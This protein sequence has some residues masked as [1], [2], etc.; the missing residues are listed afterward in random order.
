MS[1][2][3]AS[4]ATPRITKGLRKN[5]IQPMTKEAAKEIVLRSLLTL[6]AA[7]LGFVVSPFAREMWAY[8]ANSVLPRLSSEARL[9][10]L[11][12]LSTICLGLLVWIYSLTSKR[13]LLKNYQPRPGFPGVYLD[14]KN[15]E[16][17]CGICLRSKGTIS[18][19]VPHG[20]TDYW[21]V[22][23]KTDFSPQTGHPSV[24]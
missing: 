22:L 12:T 3:R 13:R 9:S 21:C 19:L 11:A 20:G 8:A 15:E 2:V 4:L 6:P 5:H 7:C 1:P 23:C 24:Q 18:P 10:I 14:T 17:V 16:K